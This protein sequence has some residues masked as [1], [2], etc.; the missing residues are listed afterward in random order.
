MSEKPWVLLVTGAAGYVGSHCVT[1]FL[2]AGFRCLVI[3]RPNFYVKPFA[4]SISSFCHLAQSDIDH[5]SLILWT[6]TFTWFL[7]SMKGFKKHI[8]T[9]KEQTKTETATNKQSFL[10]GLLRLTT[11]PMLQKVIFSVGTD[12]LTLDS[13]SNEEG[14]RRYN[15]NWKIS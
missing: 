8:H 1:E 11:F 15:E 6:D 14:S 12:F 3:M 13:H 7:L 4:R 10:A 5:R 9:H 2:N